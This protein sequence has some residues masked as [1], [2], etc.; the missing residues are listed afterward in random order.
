MLSGTPPAGAAGNYQI[1]IT[2]TNAAGT[3]TSVLNLHVDENVGTVV[4]E[5]WDGV[6][7]LTIASIPPTTLS[8]TPTGMANR[9]SLEAP[10]DYGD[11]YVG[12][13]RG[14]ITAPT[15]GNYYFW[16]AGNNA[17]ELWISNDDEP[18]NAFKR[19]G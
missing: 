10:T 3:S 12:R 18:V 5:H 16:V 4:W 9:T 1:I 14:Y 2:L 19:R 17:A 13:I 15:T 8:G 6:G 11:N 7:G